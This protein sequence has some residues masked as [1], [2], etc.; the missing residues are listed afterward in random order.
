MSKFFKYKN[1]LSKE[2]YNKLYEISR[3]ID[4][5]VQHKLDSKYSNHLIKH[6]FYSNSN[7]KITQPYKELIKC[8]SDKLNTKV[9]PHDMYF[10]I[11]QHGNECGIHVDK[12]TKNTNITFI[13]YLT[14]DWKADWHGETILYNQEETDILF[15]SIPF[16]NNALIFDS[17]LKHGVS[18]ISKNCNEDRIILVLQLNIL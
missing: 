7:K 11:Y 1:F 14:D 4:W 10:N 2:L 3:N 13:L 16:A 17:G 12:K 8:I 9:F 18:P 15:S 5:K 6:V